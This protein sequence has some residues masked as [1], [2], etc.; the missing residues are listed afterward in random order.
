MSDFPQGGFEIPCV[1][2]IIASNQKDAVKAKNQLESALN[3]EGEVTISVVNQ[4]SPQ[5]S[6]VASADSA[7]VRKVDVDASLT[8]SNDAGVKKNDDVMEVTVDLTIH[9]ESCS[10]DSPPPVKK[11]MHFYLFMCLFIKA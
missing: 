1:L 11:Q 2:K 7:T 5:T 3:I 9:S 6:D 10:T 4:D 8:A